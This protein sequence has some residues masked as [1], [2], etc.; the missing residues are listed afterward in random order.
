MLIVMANTTYY[1]TF[2]L[3]CNDTN[4]TMRIEATNLY[5]AVRNLGQALID[6]DP[7]RITSF[8]LLGEPIKR[9]DAKAD[10]KAKRK[11]AGQASALA[12]NPWIYD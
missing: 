5:Y 3:V 1:Y 10:L 4:K 7:G 8:K 2:E 11:R 12:R 9:V 6:T